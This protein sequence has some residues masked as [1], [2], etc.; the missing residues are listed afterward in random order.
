LFHPFNRQQV[1]QQH[2]G[3]D[4]EKESRRRREPEVNPRRGE[5]HKNGHRHHRQRTG[6]QPWVG[7]AF[8]GVFAGADDEDDQHLRGHGLNE[9]AGM[10]QRLPC[11]ENR[12]HDVEGEEVEG[13]FIDLAPTRYVDFVA[14]DDGII[15]GAFQSV[16]CAKE[17]SILSCIRH[18][19]C[20]ILSIDYNLVICAAVSPP[21][22]PAQRVVL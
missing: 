17:S 6:D 21:S 8:E 2:G 14:L 1:S 16:V 20:H 10:E 13:R 7:S 5:R 18:S 15:Q 9:P 11:V 4:E 12:Q 3:Q 19:R 22:Q